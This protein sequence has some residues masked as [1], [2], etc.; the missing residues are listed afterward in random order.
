M[1]LV[2]KEFMNEL[3]K[4]KGEVQ[5]LT[6]KQI[7]ILILYIVCATLVHIGAQMIALKIYNFYTKLVKKLYEKYN[8]DFNKHAL[9]HTFIATII[10]ALV[11]YGFVYVIG[12]LFGKYIIR[13][14]FYE[15]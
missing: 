10:S 9:I 5:K 8:L 1:K 7:G 14:A 2:K 4:M 6:G 3:R 13:K 11:I 12:Y 15:E